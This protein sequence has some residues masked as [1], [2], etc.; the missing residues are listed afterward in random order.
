MIEGAA[1]IKSVIPPQGVTPISGAYPARSL[2][3]IADVTRG[4]GGGILRDQTI[5]RPKMET[6][7]EPLYVLPLEPGDVIQGELVNGRWRWW[8]FETPLTSPCA[9]AQGGGA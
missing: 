9:P 3:Y 5:G 6:W 1:V 8:Y 7:R 4:G 2:G